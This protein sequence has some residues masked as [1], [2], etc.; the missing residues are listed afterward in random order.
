MQKDFPKQANMIY[1]HAS[2][3]REKIFYM[4]KK[5]QQKINKELKEHSQSQD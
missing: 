5:A 4:K 3:L 2:N 1:H